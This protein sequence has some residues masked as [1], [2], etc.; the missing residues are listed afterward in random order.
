MV[1]FTC[2]PSSFFIFC[3]ISPVVVKFIL[4]EQK[5]VYLQPFANASAEFSPN[6]LEPAQLPL[7]FIYRL[8]KYTWVRVMVLHADPHRLYQSLS[9]CEAR[10]RP[11]RRNPS[12]WKVIT[13]SHC[14]RILRP[15]QSSA[16]LRER[17]ACGEMTRYCE[18]VHLFS[19]FLIKLNVATKL[20][21]CSPSIP[22]KCC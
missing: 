2:I 22:E 6:M 20:R 10:S 9:H 15:E 19:R 8:L 17:K 13:R 5:N 1:F 16:S 18:Y 12:S 21:L 4:L 11:F 14:V 7:Y 3:S